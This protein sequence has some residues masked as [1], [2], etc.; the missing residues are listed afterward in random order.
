MIADFEYINE[1]DIQKIETYDEYMVLYR[2]KESELHADQSFDDWIGNPFVDQSVTVSE[3]MMPNPKLKL[4][5]R[6]YGVPLADNRDWKLHV[7]D[8]DKLR[9]NYY[10]EID[11]HFAITMLW[12]IGYS[13]LPNWI[14]R[15]N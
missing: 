6:Y 10:Q 13:R 14:Y 15:L 2:E 4:N 7:P 11:I 12:G 1:L 5:Q 3:V 9:L 8:F